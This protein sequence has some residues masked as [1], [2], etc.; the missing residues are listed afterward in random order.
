[1]NC[2]WRLEARVGEFHS[3]SVGIITALSRYDTCCQLHVVAFNS[4][5]NRTFFKE[6]FL[7]LA[8]VPFAMSAAVR[9]R[10]QLGISDEL[11]GERTGEG[12]R[13]Y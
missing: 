10:V 12:H 11:S 5:R 7:R 13:I 8:R 4:Y 9:F 3:V 2:R 1:M 6:C